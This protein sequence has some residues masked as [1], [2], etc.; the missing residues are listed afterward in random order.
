M[1]TL[2]L[3]LAFLYG[4]FG[5]A[6]GAAKPPGENF[7]LS[8]WKLTLP[9]NASGTNGGKATEIQASQLVAGYAN[10]DYFHT[11]TNGTMDFWCPVNGATTGGSS[12]PRSEL[13]EL[14]DPTNPAVNWTAHG[15]HILEARC[16]VTEVPSSQKVIIGQIHSYSGKAKPLIKLQF[17]KGRIEALVKV[18]PTKGKDRKLIFPQVG[19]NNGIAYQIKVQDGLLDVTVNGVTQSENI[20]QK[21]ADWENQ[22]F[23]FKAGDYCQDNQGPATEGARVSFSL[24]NVSHAESPAS[25]RESSSTDSS[26]ANQ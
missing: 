1:K 11:G 4:S 22:T 18:S 10:D 20:F 7:D 15:T 5:Y 23:Y 9:V 16:R 17:Y 3:I 21:D 14:L 12:F 6:A 19:L 26:K 2:F 13:R 25:A 8:H 24:I